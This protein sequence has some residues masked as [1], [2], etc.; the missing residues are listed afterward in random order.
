MVFAGVARKNHS[1]ISKTCCC[2]KKVLM[3][4]NHSSGV[5]I[6]QLEVEPQAIEQSLPAAKEAPGARLW[7]NRD[8][9]IFWLGQTLSV[10]GDAFATIAIPLLVL[11]ATGSV[12]VMGLVTAVFGVAQVVTGL[13]AGWLADRLDRRR[14]M[15][16]CDIL[17]TLLYFSIPLGWWL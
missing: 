4:K 5:A 16:F 11:R 1:H 9:N 14:L 2:K 13:F 7:R 3:Q 12:V 8:F 17:R 15:I 10:F 6:D